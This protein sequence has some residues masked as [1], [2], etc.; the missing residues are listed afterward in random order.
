MYSNIL[1]VNMVNKDFEVNRRF[2]KVC[3]NLLSYVES[4][5]TVSD[6]S[7]NVFHVKQTR[8]SVCMTLLFP[9]FVAEP[10]DRFHCHVRKKKIGNRPVEEAKKT[11]CCKRLIYKQFVSGFCGPQFPNFLPKRFTHLMETPYWCTVLVQLQYGR[12]KSTKTSEVHF[13]D[14]SSFFP[15]EN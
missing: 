4:V 13:F 2:S 7:I 15:L 5:W 12:R 8:L 10:I 9:Y 11:I 14:K 3:S 1:G 6:A